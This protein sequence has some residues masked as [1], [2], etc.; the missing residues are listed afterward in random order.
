MKSSRPKISVRKKRRLPRVGTIPLD[1]EKVVRLMVNRGLSISDLA[2][3]ADISRN[4]IN[5]L[6]NREG[7]YART[8]KLVADALRCP[9][10]QILP[11]DD[12]DHAENDF[13][14]PPTAEW[15]PCGLPGPWVTAS[16]G[17]QFL[18]CPMRHRHLTQRTGRG[19]LYELLSVPTDERITLNEHLLR[20]ARVGSKLVN[21]PFVAETLSV[22][23]VSHGAAWWVID[24]W[25]GGT[26]LEDRLES[27]P[28][29][30]RALLPNL[31]REIALGLKALHEAGVV[32]RELAP[33]RVLLT[34]VDGRAVLTDFELAKLL[35]GRPTVSTT[36]PD[37]PYRAPEI[38]SGEFT[39][40]ADMFSWA[41]ILVRAATGE[42]PMVMD[43]VGS[44]DQARLPRSVTKIVTSCLSLNAAKRP[45][46]VDDVLQAMSAWK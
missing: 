12:G 43:D 7:G 17:L 45:Q 24:R 42:L 33:S 8:L 11:G 6:L 44:L 32:F 13:K 26:T 46:T 23:P 25:D 18:V 5:R 34:E 27:E 15:E 31:M 10:E 35:D 14:L 20:H 40:A 1:P 28:V 16:N 29:W 4:T 37:D 9:V 22:T 21:S 39:V 3:Q 36:W 2:I 30:P 19:K 38:D 41:R